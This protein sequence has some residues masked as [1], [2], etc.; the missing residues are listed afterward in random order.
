[1]DSHLEESLRRDIA[2]IRSKAADMARLSERALEASLRALLRQ[3][4]KLAYSVILRDRFIDELE[5]ELNRLCLEFVVRHQPVAG[6]LRFV[7]TAIQINKEL[8]RIGDYAES[9]AR[10]VLAISG[11]EPQPPQTLFIELGELSIRML[12]E[13]VAAF[14]QADADLALRTMAMEEQAN[15]LRNSINAELMELSRKN[16]LTA[17]ALT[18][19][20]TIARRFERAS[21]QAKN[22]CEEVLYMCTG[23]FAKHKGVDA[24]RILF[25]DMHNACLSQIAEGIANSIRPPRFTFSSAGAAPQALDFRAVDFMAGKGLDISGQA[26]KPLEKVPQWEQYQVV[27]ALGTQARKAFPKQA[28]KTICFTWTVEDPANVEGP[29][30]MV[31]TAFESAFQSLKSQIQ[32]LLGAILEEPQN[33]TKP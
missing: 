6:D 21:D 29:P 23:E 7:F 17:G 3:D 27:V 16:Q 20:M 24:F 14:L 13:S 12:R 1:M 11:L 10:Q 25:F 19:L 18:P 5:T 8:E 31:R 28:G 33:Q 9:V 32:E 15:G 4:R 2:L 30:D 26:S 22:L